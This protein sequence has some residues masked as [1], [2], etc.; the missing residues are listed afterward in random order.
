MA[1]AS[2]TTV[3]SA[4]VPIPQYDRTGS[5]VGRPG[6]RSRRRA[7]GAGTTASPGRP[8]AAPPGTRGRR[9]T[10]PAT[11]AR[12]AARRATR[13][14]PGPTASTTPAPSWP[15]AI[16]RRSRPLA[17]ADVEV[18]V[19]DAGRQHPDPDLA[20]TRLGQRR[21]SRSPSASPVASAARP[22]G[23]ACSRLA[24]P[25]PLVRAGAGSYGTYA[26]HHIAASTVASRSRVGRRCPASPAD[27]IASRAT[28]IAIGARHRPQV[29][30]RRVERARREPLV[31]RPR[32][33]ASGRR[34]GT[35]GR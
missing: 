34:A 28:A 4:I 13:P 31:G 27:S 30:D 8:T 18:G 14:T 6:A 22:P 16:G 7:C 23:R 32:R 29:D 24:R 17:V 21:A 3:A 10:A 11:T 35:S 19:A 9:R 15:I 1:A 20:G 5:P 25:P 26:G 33:P 12:P 2:G